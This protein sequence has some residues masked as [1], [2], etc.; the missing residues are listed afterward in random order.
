MLLHA[1]LADPD[2]PRGRKSSPNKEP[3][4]TF[5]Q[6][7]QLSRE[8]EELLLRVKMFFLTVK[9]RYYRADRSW[10]SFEWHNS[11]KDANCVWRNNDNYWAT[12]NN[13]QIWCLKLQFAERKFQM[14]MLR[15]ESCMRM[16]MWRCE[17][18]LVSHKD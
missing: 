2:S 16:Y 7:V 8:P 3:R 15:R 14:G 6:Q 12:L 9:S 10:N 1:E 4:H 5:S 18:W 17:Q 13:L 11:Q